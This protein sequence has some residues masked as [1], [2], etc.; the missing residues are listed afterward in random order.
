MIGKKELAEEA[1]KKF[2][3]QQLIDDYEKM[4]GYMFS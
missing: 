4:L 3:N 1:K 2:K